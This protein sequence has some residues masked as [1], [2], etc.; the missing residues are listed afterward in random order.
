MKKAVLDGGEI[1]DEAVD[2]IH[3]LE[4]EVADR[5]G[6]VKIAESELDNANAGKTAIA[7]I[8]ADALRLLEKLDVADK[9]A[10]ERQGWQIAAEEYKG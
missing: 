3:A 6:D 5:V 9:Y 8:L 2:I 10:F 4:V 7:D 1:Y